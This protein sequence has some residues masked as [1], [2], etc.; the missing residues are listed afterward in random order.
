MEEQEQA[1]VKKVRRLSQY[2]NDVYLRS[3]EEKFQMFI[4]DYAVFYNQIRIIYSKWYPKAKTYKD[5]DIIANLFIDKV[6]VKDRKTRV[7][8]SLACLLST[9]NRVYQN[10]LVMPK[11]DPRFLC[12]MELLREISFE[13]ATLMQYAYKIMEGKNIDFG[14]WKR[15][16]IDPQE[17]FIASSQILRKYTGRQTQGNFVFS[18]TAIF[19]IRQSIELWLQSIFGIDYATDD[20]NKLVKLQPDKLFTLLDNQGKLVQLPIPK[21]IILKIHQWTQSFV[22]AG[23][24]PPIWE[25]E[26]AQHVLAPIF[27]SKNIKINT[28]HFNSIE[29]QLRVVLKIPKLILYR[30]EKA[31]YQLM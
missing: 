22:H 9:S 29:E 16:Y 12:E 27:I 3:D 23:W 21:S 4:S 30:Y 25:I 15:S 28:K 31:E 13:A 2:I 7:K 14:H 6:E 26:H 18:P 1:I 8:Y 10:I 20:K 17:T 5:D 24:L 19:M 11:D